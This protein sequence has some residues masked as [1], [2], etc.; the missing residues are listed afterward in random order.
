MNCCNDPQS[1]TVSNDTKDAVRISHWR[2][3]APSGAVFEFPW[4]VVLHPGKDRVVWC[5][6]ES[7][8][9]D[10]LHWAEG[11]ELFTEQPTPV[12]LYTSEGTL[13]A[14]T[15]AQGL[16]P[17]PAVPAGPALCLEPLVAGDKA[18]VQAALAGDRDEEVVQF[19]RG[20][21]IVNMTRDELKCMG[22][23][24][25][26]NDKAI[27]IYM[28]LVVMMRDSHPELPAVELIKQSF[29]YTRLTE[30]GYDYAGVSSWTR[31]MKDLLDKDKLLVPINK[32][33][34]HWVLA[35]IN[36]RDK[37]FEFYDA[38]P[39][40]GSQCFERKA[41]SNLR[42][43]IVD[44]SMDKRR[45]DLDLSDWTDYIPTAIPHQDNG[46]DCGMFAVKYAQAVA[47]DLNL[48]DHPF[49]QQHIEDFRVRAIKEM[50][51][52]KLD[53]VLG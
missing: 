52:K 51:D 4:G 41:L 42:R 25:W 14:Q 15:E 31:K 18:R 35:V 23:R 12:E 36:I 37:R 9:D 8:A 47:L 29:F 7:P 11:A 2:L 45:V 10:E 21:T 46:V 24:Q 20:R 34:T 33:C 26:L 50:M 19:K 5:T 1:I 44:E 32:D 39:C 53:I 3:T 49:G 13:K 16:P 43:W 40:G 22:P 30:G 17:P 27:Q 48:E 6:V 38:L 28:N